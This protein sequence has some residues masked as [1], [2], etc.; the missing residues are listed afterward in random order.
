MSLWCQEWWMKGL[1]VI[2]VTFIVLVLIIYQRGIISLGKARKL[3]EMSKWGFLEE[4]GNG[5]EDDS[6]ERIKRKSL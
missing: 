5:S 6:V 2:G 4:L 1:F 3:A